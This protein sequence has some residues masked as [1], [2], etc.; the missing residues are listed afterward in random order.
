MPR[1]RPHVAGSAAQGELAAALAE[2]RQQM[3]LPDGFPD[4][5]LAEAEGT[6]SAAPPPS[7]DR[8]DLGF[9]TIDP[10][11]SRDL[12]QALHL[13]R[14]PGGYTVDYA[15]ADVPGFVRPD[16]AIDMEARERGQT[17]YA[18]DGR[19][20]LHPP[21]LGEDRASLLPGVDRSAYVW[22]F[23]LDE[24]GAVAAT[25]LERALVRSREQLDYVEAQRRVDSESPDGS[26]ALLREIGELRAE[27]E[28]AR[29]GASLNIPEEQIVRTPAG[30]YALERRRLLPVEDWNA[31]LSLMTGMAA[32]ELMIAARVGILRTM[33]KPSDEDVASFRR[34]AE[35]LGRPWPDSIGYGEYLRGLPRDEPAS[36]AI[37]QAAGG[38]FRGAGYAAMDGTVPNDPVQSA[39]AAPYAHVTAPLRRLVD[40]WGLVV[41]AAVA[42]GH[43]VPGWARASLA[44]L[45][46]LMGASSQR[47]AQLDAASI[48][49]VE[50]AVLAERVGERFE[51]TVLQLR[52]GWAVIQLTDPAVTAMCEAT[53][54][55]RPGAVLAV[56]LERADIRTGTVEFRAAA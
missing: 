14:R 17:L 12:D 30:G 19:V 1:R 32:A 48:A 55:A 41:C 7:A 51:A 16:G 6:T 47:A 4:A 53:A 56:V 28:R 26:L 36:L 50:A 45:P 23:D 42:G 15:I 39:L 22:S 37:L 8:R 18:A 20:P 13:A 9:V 25:R 40:R 46:S 3:D 35:A 52:N 38:L 2:L 21:V 43:E 54:A 27:Q 34:Q 10:A 31:Q 24:A 49:R 11:G 33:P 44:Q 29:G 5:V